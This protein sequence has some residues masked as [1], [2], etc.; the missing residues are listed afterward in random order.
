MGLL[1][2][3]L[4]LIVAVLVSNLVSKLLPTIATPL[5]QIALGMALA[6]V[7]PGFGDFELPT[8]L[9]MAV[10]VAPLIYSDSRGID[11]AR[12]WHSRRTIL[13][14]AIGLV[15]ANTLVVGCVMGALVAPLSMAAAFVLGAAL[16]P[17]DT[18]SVSA[19]AATTNITRRQ[20]AILSGESLVNDATGVVAFNLA[21]ST[22]VTGSFSLLDAGTSF[23]WLFFGGIALGL[24]LGV[25]GNL[26]TGAVRRLGCDDVVF[27][28][29]FD[30][31]MPF[32][33]FLVGEVAGVSSI[34]AVMVCALAFKTGV[35]K[36]GPDESRMNIVSGS[37]WN[38][39][40]FALNGIVFVMLGFQL[41]AA[42]QDILTSGVSAAEL[43]GAAA[44]LVALLMGLRLA[45]AIGMEFLTRRRLRRHL[46]DM[47]RS[48]VTSAEFVLPGAT[49][50]EVVHGAAV[51]AFA[52]GAKGATTL[53]IAMSVPY[54]VGA[55]SLIVFLVSVAIIVT[56]VLA[57]V[58]VPHLAPAPRRSGDEEHD[59]LRRAK[60]KILRAVVGQL[61]ADAESGESG[62]EKVTRM[63][64]SE[65]NRRISSIRAGLD[66]GRLHASRKAVRVLALRLEAQCISELMER[67]EV[68]ELAGYAYLTRLA[69][70]MR[71]L[72]ASSRLGWLFEHSL[73]RARGVFRAAT[74]LLRERVRETLSREE[75]EDADERG[76]TTSSGVP[77]N[78]DLQLR[79]ARYVVDHL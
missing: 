77:T 15:I 32:V 54:A 23:L 46:D 38:V 30:V 57:N 10:F 67:G 33:T 53:S 56:I 44:L 62:D 34:M 27:H 39:L 68:S 19:I 55:R 17:T 76:D 78:R 41:K 3:A 13:K 12:A 24:A 6:L 58:L 4:M 45:W 74:G 28:V 18:V 63:V 69:R 59:Q 36:V 1:V 9:F 8:S 70:L 16:S 2:T 50:R 42:I 51:L 60:L 64:I 11:R 49:D 21:L 61:S 22:L 26:V 75:D 7:L 79:C 71:A 66:D 47:A 72:D 35:G 52:G 40:S 37:V 73:R 43:A 65:Y 5:V 25:A 29:L 14:L 20:R 31:A 48:D